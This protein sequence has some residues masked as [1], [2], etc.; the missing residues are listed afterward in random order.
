[1]SDRP[2]N[3]ISNPC[4][5]NVA[6]TAI[7]DLESSPTLDEDGARLYVVV[8]L[9]RKVALNL[10]FARS[11]NVIFKPINGANPYITD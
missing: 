9:Y 4:R 8:A 3:G 11:L 5:L 7:S 10:P 6:E 2:K 1:M